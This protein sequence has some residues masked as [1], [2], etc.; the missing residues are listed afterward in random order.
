MR[1]A[2]PGWQK[3]G[4]KCDEHQHRRTLHA[5]NNKIQQFQQGRICPM[6]IFVHSEDRLMRRES[7]ELIDQYIQRPL[8]LPVRAQLQRLIATVRR[9]RQQRREQ[10]GRVGDIVGR[11][12]E[13]RLE[14][15]QFHCRGIVR[16]EASGPLQK[17]NNRIKRTV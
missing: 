10:R 16:G 17:A 7:N 1:M 3:L 9:N 14:L 4:A 12:R 13:Q 5:F 2:H 8:L 11:L 6:H 15:A